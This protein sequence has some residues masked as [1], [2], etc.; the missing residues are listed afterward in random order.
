MVRRPSAP[1]L[2]PTQNSP[3]V[4][5][6]TAVP[7]TVIVLTWFAGFDESPIE[8]LPP[9]ALLKVPPERSTVPTPPS[10]P[11]TNQLLT[12][13]VPPL[14][15]HVPMPDCPELFPSPT[16]TSPA[17]VNAPPLNV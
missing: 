6:K 4:L 2:L 1:P 11:T 13:A 12:F 9:P 10:R 5:L 8:V 15:V 16:K 3:A 14:C 17:E 7:R